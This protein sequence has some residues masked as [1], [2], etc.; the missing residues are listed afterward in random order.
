MV[1]CYAGF[2]MKKCAK[3]VSIC[4][5]LALLLLPLPLIPAA[6]ASGAAGEVTAQCTYALPENVPLE[7]LTDDSLLTRLTVSPNKNLTV[8]LRPVGSPPCT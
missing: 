1:V 3:I 4:L 7:R 8:K 2:V 6:E 5:L